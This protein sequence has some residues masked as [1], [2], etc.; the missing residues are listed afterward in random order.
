MNTTSPITDKLDS[1]ACLLRMERNHRDLAQLSKK[2]NSYICEPRT[3]TLFERI[4][5]LRNRLE[6]LKD[7]NSEIM[8]SLK[9]HKKNLGNQVER[10]K[11]QFME[12]REL[13]K[14]VAEYMAGAR[15]C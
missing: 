4:E 7:N 8:A 12:F 2:L 1:N 14:C 13:E 6:R 3:Y 10:I 15:N 5:I 11:Q 9:G